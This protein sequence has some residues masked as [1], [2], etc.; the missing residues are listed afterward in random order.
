[1]AIKNKKASKKNARKS[2]IPY[3]YL[4]SK[5]HPSSYITE[6][7]QKFIV[8]LEY[9][10]L[11]GKY[12]AFQVTSSVSAEGKSTFIGNIAYL[13]AKKGQKVIVLDLDFRKPKI[14]RL[15]DVA[16]ENGIA[17]FLSGK[18]QLK[19]AIIKHKLGFDAMVRGENTSA[20]VNVLTSDKL[21]ALIQSL[22]DSYDYILVDSPPVI[23][24]SDALYIAQIVDATVFAIAQSETSRGL[25][26]D[27]V[28][29][30]RQNN[31]NLIG[32]VIIQVNLKA[33]RYGYGYGY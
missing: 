21:K 16:N 15:L 32:T 4:Y 7:F 5:E 20:V 3:N 8:N 31:V 22:K 28:A 18:I 19:D 33:S 14:H 6:A 30:L 13:L 23:S 2:L 27:A 24:V 12:K 25:I 26:K 29:L 1:M 17:E 11:D 10:N 9:I